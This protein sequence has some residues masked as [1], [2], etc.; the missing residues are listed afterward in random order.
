M[1]SRQ[2]IRLILLS[3]LLSLPS[4]TFS[5]PSN[6]SSDNTKILSN[7]SSDTKDLGWY[8]Q[9][10]NVMG[11][12]SEGGFSQTRNKLTFTGNTNTNGGGF[13]SIRTQPAQFDLSHYDGIRLNLSADGRRYSWTLQTDATYRG[14]RISYWADFETSKGERITVD[15]P[16]SLFRPQFRGL[17]LDGPT[18][19]E[20]QIVEMGLYI[21]DKQ[22]GPFEIQLTSILAYKQ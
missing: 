20:S 6:G 10:D 19:D 4:M 9:N 12:R 7:F 13:S 5:D 21:Y 1:S 14:R 18:L 2:T 8:S 22:D 16:F 3:L 17:K 15:I 11:G